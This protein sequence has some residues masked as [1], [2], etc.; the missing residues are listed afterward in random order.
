MQRGWG[1]QPPDLLKT[2]E[3]LLV[4]K[5]GAPSQANLRRAM[6]TTYYALFHHLAK[7]GA[8]LFVGATRGERRSRGAWRQA[9]RA[10]EHRA[11]KAACSDEK[12]IPIFPPELIDYAFV[13]RS[14]Q[15]NRHN[16][17]YDPYYKLTRSQVRIEINNVQR[18]IAGFDACSNKDRRAFVALVLFKKRPVTA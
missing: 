16:A 4:S 14:M 9:Y 8:D 10:L 18:V 12:M 17:D 11:A 7:A 15:E 2:A 13:F 3:C 6:S 5:S 1:L